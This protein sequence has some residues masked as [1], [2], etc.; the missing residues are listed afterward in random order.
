M[1]ITRELLPMQ[2]AFQMQSYSGDFSTVKQY[3]LGLWGVLVFGSLDIR[4]LPTN[5]EVLTLPKSRSGQL[6]ARYALIDV[7]ICLAS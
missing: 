4:L 7:L 6:G 1:R 5:T 3:R 2:A